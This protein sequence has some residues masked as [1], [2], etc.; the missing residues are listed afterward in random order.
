MMMLLIYDILSVLFIILVQF[1]SLEDDGVSE[2]SGHS[3]TF[4]SSGL[5]GR[6]FC[7]EKAFFDCCT[8]SVDLDL[9]FMCF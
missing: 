5:P 6:D 1:T 2:P 9:F 7:E 3:F 8:S 4:S